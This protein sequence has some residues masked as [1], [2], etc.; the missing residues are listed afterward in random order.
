MSQQGL[1]GNLLGFLTQHL[2][3]NNR[4]HM[5]SYAPPFSEIFRQSWTTTCQGYCRINLY[6]TNLEINQIPSHVFSNSVTTRIFENHLLMLSLAD[7]SLL[8]PRRTWHSK[9]WKKKKKL[10]VCSGLENRDQQEFPVRTE[11]SCFLVCDDTLLVFPFMP[12]KS[13]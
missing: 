6:N 2:T 8:D 5:R 10:A 7:T 12:V 1:V 9:T 11:V 3:P 13:A 4:T